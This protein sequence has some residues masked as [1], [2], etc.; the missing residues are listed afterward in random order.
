MNNYY[1][2]VSITV[3]QTC[4]KFQSRCAVLYHVWHHGLQVYVPQDEDI[5]TFEEK[6]EKER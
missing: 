4:P 3:Y 1:I 5:N 2:T 6:K